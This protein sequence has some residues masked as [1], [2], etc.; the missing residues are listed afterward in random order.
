MKI[1]IDFFEQSL[2]QVT[3]R[4][5]ELARAYAWCSYAPLLTALPTTDCDMFKHCEMDPIAMLDT[6]T[7]V[8]RPPAT[9]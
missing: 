6:A 1:A 2:L 5:A 7:A 9:V 8:V 4:S 3:R